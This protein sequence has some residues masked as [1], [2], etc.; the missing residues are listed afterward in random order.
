[1]A[2]IVTAMNRVNQIY[3][4]EVAIRMQI[5]A[6]ND[7]AI[8]TDNSTDPYTNGSSTPML[9]ENR[10]TLDAVI[11]VSNYDIGHVFSTGGGGVANLGVPC[12]ASMP[13]AHKASGV[14]GL[15]RPTGDP[16]YV[17]FV[18]HEMGHQFGAQHTWNA[19]LP[20]SPDFAPPF[21]GSCTPNQYS[22]STAMEPGSGS[23]IMAY[24][25]I[26]SDQDL[27]SSS[28]EY[29]HGKS[30]DEIIGYSTQGPGNTCPQI[31]STGNA[32]PDVDAGSDYTIPVGTP[33]TLC[34]SGSDAD[35]DALTYAWEQF[36][37]GPQGPPSMPRGNAPIF[38]SFPPASE[39]CRTFPD[40][41]DQLNG[42]QT[43]GEIL[44]TYARTLNFRLTARDNRAGGGGLSDD[45]MQV[46]VVDTAGPFEVL[47]PN[48]SEG[49][50]GGE[51]TTVIWDPAGTTAPPVSCAAVD[52]LLFADGDM[53]DSVAL[54]RNTLNDG[55]QTVLIPSLG[56][57]TARVKVAC[58]GNVF[59]DI[60]D[61]DFSVSNS[62]ACGQ[63]TV[64]SNQT[65]TGVE[66]FE[67]ESSITAGTDL[68]VGVT[69]TLRLWS[70]GTVNL[71]PGFRVRAGGR[72][73]AGLMSGLCL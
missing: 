57:A 65:I 64:L 70:G 8:Y 66:L 47:A 61:A 68:V 25:G 39:P 54:S 46:R 34:G 17:D 12:Q 6:N 20:V 23:T 56:T 15:S 58:S 71:E 22:A 44:P 2:A 50:T 69:G 9:T 37:T 19:G 21:A 43:I 72:F 10:R 48:G 63:D 51:Q 16:F 13:F 32:A 4:R 5:V 14:T 36:D 18:A 55:S 67:D 3:E 73:Q 24:A 31:S 52:I 38:R 59:F 33:F 30:L 42:T 41:T 49:L 27:Q 35:A 45:R 40:V 29:F 62:P 28:D 53:T 60:A 1:M 7:L 11:G 26:C